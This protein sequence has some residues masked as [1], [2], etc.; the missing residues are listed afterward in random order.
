[1]LQLIS[2]KPLSAHKKKKI[3]RA[4]TLEDNSLIYGRSNVF[5][6]LMPHCF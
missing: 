1:M 4:E 3:V 6:G 2:N 5:Q